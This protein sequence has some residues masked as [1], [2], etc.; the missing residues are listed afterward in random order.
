MTENSLP[1]IGELVAGRYRI[2]QELG[3][4][5]YGVVYRARQDVMGRDVALKVL[6]PEAAKKE[7]E[8]ERFRR[9]VFHASGL[10]HPNTIQL[11]DFGETNGLFY[12]VMEY[13]EGMNLRDWVMSHG[14][15][16]HDQSVEATSQILKSLREAHEHGIVHRDLKPENIFLVDMGE[17]DE[18]FV[19]VLD[20]G[21]SKYVEGN[22]MKEPTLTKEGVIFGTP[23]YMSPEQAYGQKVRPETDIYSVGL[24]IY[25][26][27][28]ARCAFTGRSSMEILIKQVSQPLPNLPDKLQGTILDDFVEIATQKEM[29][30]RFTDAGEA[31]TW[32]QKRRNEISMVSIL[33]PPELPDPPEAIEKAEDGADSAEIDAPIT[34]DIEGSIDTSDIFVEEGEMLDV[35][36]RLAQLPLVGRQGELDQLM[37]WSRQALFT[38]GVAWITGDLGIGK[39]RLV[40]EWVH[41][42]EMEGV[43]VLRGT[44]YE[45]GAPIEG[46]RDALMPIVDRDTNDEETIPR[47]LTLE[48]LKGLRS[49]LMP[50]ESAEIS[51]NSGQD[52]AFA[53]IEQSLFS[54][55]STKPTVLFLEN[56]QWA[57]SF[58]LRLIDH[59]Q[60]E[61]ATR[62]SPLL[63][64]M[65]SRTDEMGASQKLDQLSSLG[66]RYAAVSFANSIELSRLNHE[67]SRRLL[68]HIATLAEDVQH[69]ICDLARGNPLFL[70]QIVR[71]MVEE[72]LLEF[73]ESAGVWNFVE[74]VDTR[75]RLVPPSISALLLRR[76]KNLINKHRLGAVLKAILTRAMLLGNRFEMRL[77]KAVLRRESRNDL[78]SYFD[79]A[80]ERLSRS[81]ILRATVIANQPG[82]E[83]VY[84]ITRKSLLESQVSTGEDLTEL[85]RHIAAVKVDFY[86]NAPSDRRGELAESIAGHYDAAGEK[87]DALSWMLKAATHIETAQDFRG[88][89]DCYRESER[90]L[91]PEIDPDGERLLDIRLAQGR[92]HRFL[93]EYGPAEYALRA[94]F[95]EAARVGDV[96]GEA[97]AGESIADVLKL[98]ARYEE[99]REF[100]ERTRELYESFHDKAGALRCDVGLSE[101]ERFM[102]HYKVSSEIFEKALYQGEE[103][104]DEEIVVR[105]LYGLGQC[106]YAAGELHESI[107]LFQRARKRAESIDDWR[108]VSTCDVDIAMVHILTHGVRKAEELCKSALDAKRKLGDTRGQAGAHLILSMAL[109]R[110]TRLDDAE[111]HARR[112][113]ALNERL[114]HKYG[115]AKS[116]LIE[117]EISWVRG[118]VKAA[119]ARATD[120]IKMHEDIDDQHG[121]ALALIFSG[122]FACEDGDFEVARGYLE[123]AMAIGGEKGLGLY[124]PNCLLFLGMAYEGEDN[125]EEAIA[126]YGEALQLAED[127]GNRE[128]ASLTAISLAKLHLVLGDLEAVKAEIPIARD[129]AEKL[130]NNI[131]LLLAF[132]GEAW[133][134]N[135][136]NN[137]HVLQ[138]SLQKLRVLNDQRSGADL[139]IPQR[140]VV[141]AHQIRRNSPPEKADDAIRSVL[142]IIESLDADEVA[143]KARK[144]LFTTEQT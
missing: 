72:N 62:S 20:F 103:L 27:V 3:R 107:E 78:E 122:L 87:R 96:V 35:E 110:S 24:L 117:G 34:G 100:Y 94:G 61:M 127:M 50:E 104:G 23:Q 19:K 98:L 7:S 10:R 55:S 65:T 60:E 118:N 88:A 54:I 26:M 119:R 48:A 137:P 42:F 52:W 29:T 9:E 69:Y 6:N 41:H 40:E 5:G 142:E 125:L 106:A 66:R 114:S 8:V 15:L 56:L 13:L 101:I 45:G 108:M 31:Y 1:S 44:Y 91:S 22:P 36:M 28:T 63:L 80:L 74:G 105:S 79:D 93:G 85:N 30:D 89:L 129:Q 130:G 86:D 132:T 92:L 109:R 2:L 12:I 124:Q 17:P 84:N 144:T 133:L 126:Y 46:L 99:S 64:V 115:T 70:T 11:F 37:E 143:E 14:P 81:G 58:T 120:A 75:E 25:E 140:L 138:R 77:L 135:M 67:D 112:A 141:L 47:T 97:L 73:E 39:T 134:A 136:T 4:G 43:L 76:I 71:Y 95:E 18:I 116:I 51:T 121:L 49:I 123:R 59:W 131:A 16:K 21:L 102:G 53:H 38:G 113:L 128:M 57:D 33:R 111:Y 68:S 83:F 90:L 32:I 139:R 82:L